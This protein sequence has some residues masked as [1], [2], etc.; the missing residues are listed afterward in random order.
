MSH[1][2]FRNTSLESYPPVEIGQPVADLTDGHW[3]YPYFDCGG[4]DIWM[5]TYSSP[6]F[7]LEPNT[8]KPTFK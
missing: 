6:V 5:V 2:C 4:G 8:Q 3:T 1:P 7:G